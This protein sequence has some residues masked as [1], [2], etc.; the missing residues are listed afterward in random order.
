MGLADQSVL[1]PFTL[2]LSFLF[3]ALPPFSFRYQSPLGGVYSGADILASFGQGFSLRPTTPTPPSVFFLTLLRTLTHT[4]SLGLAVVKGNGAAC[5]WC[6]SHSFTGI[7]M[8]ASTRVQH[9]GTF[10]VFL[11]NLALH[12]ANAVHVTS[13]FG[14]MVVTGAVLRCLSLPFTLYGDQCL[15]R[16]ATA[17][18]DL[19]VAY[20]EYRSVAEH[21]RAV[22]WEKK[23]V[24]R[25]LKNDR[26]RIF[27]T[28]HT[29]NVRMTVP[30]AVGLLLSWYA[31][32]SPAHLV[33]DYLT[34]TV[35]ATITSPLVITVPIT[36]Q[37]LSSGA[38]IVDPTLCVAA[39]VTL[40]NVLRHLQRREGFNNLL[41]ARI[42]TAKRYAWGTYGAL[43]VATLVVAPLVGVP[44]TTFVPP[45]IV[46][47]W[48]G[49]SL[50]TATKTVLCNGT[51]PG[52]ALCGIA[53]YPPLHG[54]YG[55]VCTA[56]SHEIRIELLGVDTEEK[57]EQWQ[58]QKRL[59]EYE[60]DHRL[61][62]FFTSLGIFDPVEEME[63]EADKLRRKVDV[64]RI[65][66]RQRRDAAQ[67]GEESVDGKA[68]SEHDG[69]A[70]GSPFSGSIGGASVSFES[71]PEPSA[72]ET[73]VPHRT[74]R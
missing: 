7:R 22:S 61:H 69:K 39:T 56:E 41:D 66:R 19:H 20:L 60:C 55:N 68:E 62:R 1:L 70:Y 50:A 63:Y 17:L 40:F 21:P 71:S 18:P 25:K 5:S 54:S 74:R 4:K 2:L 42:A 12:T 38:L 58:T 6:E 26:E 34:Y 9:A 15:S 59:L 67:E 52:R 35:G 43:S 8:F 28:Y 45:Y 65:R 23:V 47:A 33:S 53:D 14:V 36:T 27:R 31:L 13:P 51:A 46:P 11:A 57:R 24:A 72:S 49:I 10:S 16:V 37:L 48:L 29:S 64:V 3:F 32:A 30:H 44:V 73:A